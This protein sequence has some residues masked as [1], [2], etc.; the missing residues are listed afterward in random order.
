M[1]RPVMST[2][3]HNDIIPPV[4]GAGM[5][6][7]EESSLHGRIWIP[8]SHSTPSG[9]P[10]GGR[11]EGSG[12]RHV[13]DAQTSTPSWVLVSVDRPRSHVSHS[14]SR[15]NATGD[16]RMG[17]PAMPHARAGMSNDEVM[18]HGEVEKL[19]QQMFQAGVQ[20]AEKWQGQ[21]PCSSGETP[22]TVQP[23]LES[24]RDIHAVT[25][26][27]S[28]SVTRPTPCIARVPQTTTVTGLRDAVSS[29]ATTTSSCVSPPS[30]VVE[31]TRSVSRVK[32][33]KVANYSGK[34]SWAD[35]LVQFNIAAKLN[36][37]DEDCKAM[38][39][40]TSLEGNARGVLADLTPEQQLDF[41]VLVS[42]LT[43]RFEPEGQLGI[44]QTQLRN[45]K[46]KRNE[47]IPELLQE[48]SSVVRK[49]I[50]PLMNRRE[51]IWPFPA[52]FLH[53]AMKLKN[54][55]CIRRS[56]L[57][58]MKLERLL[59]VLKLF[60]LVVVKMLLWSGCN[61]LKIPQAKCHPGLGTG[62]RRWNGSWTIGRSSQVEDAGPLVGVQALARGGLVLVIIVV[63]RATGGHQTPSRTENNT[64]SDGDAAP[65]TSVMPQVTT[66]G[67]RV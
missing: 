66:S 32:E 21:G 57:I 10:P 34:S 23:V 67:N 61:S 55:S 13:K 63:L 27:Q 22:C 42:K 19:F 1:D 26:M 56:Q 6:M 50:Q 62:F 7:V 8:T 15:P 5:E 30:P 24:N 51:A 4:S 18:T 54:Y 58:W 29:I 9:P 28:Q 47:T 46:R 33:K 20:W 49:P 41:N 36:C 40:A 53:W 59:W 31:T 11:E 48:I 45:R 60:R 43:P 65:V 44:H 12:V 38:E 35:Y 2:H 17:Q 64:T 37:C 25:Q 14:Q 3:V 39:L 52:S 16:V